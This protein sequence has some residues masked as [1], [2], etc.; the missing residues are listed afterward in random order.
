MVSSPGGLETIAEAR[1]LGADLICLPHLS[2][3]PYVAARRDRAGLEWAERPPAASYRQALEAAGGAWLSASTYES[4]GE[5]V[6]Y[7]TAR[8]SRAGEER[9]VY[10][11]RHVEA[12]PGR[13]E[14]MFWSPGHWPPRVVEMPWGRTGLLVGF[15]LR[16]PQAWAQLAE[17]GATVVLG[18]ASE[19]HE[20]WQRTKRL[21]AGM[22]AAYDLTAFIANREGVEDGTEFAGGAATYGAGGGSIAATENGLYELEWTQ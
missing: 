14:Q 5:G 18:G 20:L 15:D 12:A 6:F 17:L 21:A 13:F 2:F 22:A 10:R 3:M 4:E 9:I 1:A 11:Q 16:V 7:A 19:P 8:L